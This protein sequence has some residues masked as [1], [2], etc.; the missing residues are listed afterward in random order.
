MPLSTPDQSIS[1]LFNFRTATNNHLIPSWGIFVQ[2]SLADVARRSQQP[3]NLSEELEKKVLDKAKAAKEAQEAADLF[4]YQATTTDDEAER[5]ELLS[6]S[7]DKEKEARAHSKEARRIASG[8]WQGTL[9]GA[10]IGSGVGAGLGTVVGTLVGTIAAIPMA[11]LGALIGLP[12]GL[13][14][15][16]FFKIGGK[17]PAQDQQPSEDEQ[18]QAVLQA[19]DKFDQEKE[20]ESKESNGGGK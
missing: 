3:H 9:T 11:G 13:I 8:A 16:P 20:G 2:M 4:K 19:V 1:R 14:N 17:Q 5:N 15:G 18:H 6:K 10:G 7:K 12:V